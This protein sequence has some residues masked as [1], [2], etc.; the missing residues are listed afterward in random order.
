MVY[1][2]YLGKMEINRIHTAAMRHALLR[3]IFSG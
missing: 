1:V 2:I 3:I